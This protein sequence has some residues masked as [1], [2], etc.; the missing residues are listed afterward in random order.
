[1][2]DPGAVVLTSPVMAFSLSPVIKA[3]LEQ[4]QPPKQ[5]GARAADRRRHRSARRHRVIG[6][7]TTLAHGGWA[8]PR[9]DR[10]GVGLCGGSAGASRRPLRAPPIP[11]ATRW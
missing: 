6:S 7:H 4:A 9:R 8:C 11:H 10:A 1:M 3:Y 2:P 5:Y